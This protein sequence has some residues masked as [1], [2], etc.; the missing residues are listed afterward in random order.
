MI[1][2]NYK[3]L[4][5]LINYLELKEEILKPKPMK[6][7]MQELIERLEDED[8][9]VPYLIKSV[10]LEKEKEQIINTYETGSSHGMGVIEDGLDYIHGIEY[11]DQT[12]NQNSK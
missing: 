5:E 11:F 2:T 10:Y 1:N 7:A 6:T 4:T 3:P 9:N 8:I 12:Y